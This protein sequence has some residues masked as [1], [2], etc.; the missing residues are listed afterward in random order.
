M[1]RRSLGR[2]I[3]AIASAWLLQDT[4][5]QSWRRSGPTG[6]LS[7]RTASLGRGLPL[8]EVGLMLR[9]L[10]ILAFLLL[11]QV[12]AELTDASPLGKA[13]E[14]IS[15]LKKHVAED[16]VKEQEAYK[17]YKEKK[18]QQKMDAE[19]YEAEAGVA[20]AAAQIQKFVSQVARSDA[21][22]NDAKE[23]R[24]QEKVSFEDWQKSLSD[25]IK[26]LDKAGEVLAQEKKEAAKTGLLQVSSD[27][28]THVSDMLLALASLV[29]ATALAPRATE[30]MAFAQLQGQEDARAPNGGYQPRSGD[31]IELLKDMQDEAEK[32]LADLRKT[33]AEAA[34]TFKL[35]SASLKRQLDDS[36]SSEDP[37]DQALEDNGPLVSPI[38]HGS[39]L[40]KADLE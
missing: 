27:E 14:L 4:F 13:L 35:L 7:A 19:I 34:H 8:N 37:H 11:L 32:N 16:G 28:A 33:E 5:I 36:Q 23:V 40:D 10:S 38:P 24:N 6:S 15:K 26:L 12:Q 3:L 1:M 25:T 20:S 31:L 18:A 29:D 9:W 30:L 2:I 22:L 21:K 17:K 39:F